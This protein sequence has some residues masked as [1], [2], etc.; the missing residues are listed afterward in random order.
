[1]PNNSAYKAAGVDVEAGYESVRLM[2]DDVKRTF[3]EY[4][5]SHLGG[6]GGLIELPEGYKK[7]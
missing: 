7:P 4:V 3:N 5:L 6:F 2:K 1:M